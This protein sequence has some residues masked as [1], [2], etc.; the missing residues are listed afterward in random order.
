MASHDLKSCF[1]VG[2]DLD[3]LVVV[4]CSRRILVYRVE[5]LLESLVVH[6]LEQ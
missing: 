3:D 4:Q 2:W 1:V 6:V 5:R